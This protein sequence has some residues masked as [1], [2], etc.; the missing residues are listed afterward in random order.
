MIS[1]LSPWQTAFSPSVER[2]SGRSLGSEQRSDMQNGLSVDQQRQ[3]DALRAVDRKVRAH[4]L[5]HVAVG[6]GLVGAASFSYQVGPDKQRYA[7]AGEVSID[8]SE[9]RDAEETIARAE[10]IRAAAL[11]PADPSSQDRRVAALATRMETAARQKL[12]SEGSAVNATDR[13]PPV[14]S[15]LAAYQLPFQAPRTIGF[16]VF[17]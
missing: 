12:A 11:A 5:A 7:V 8:V 16:S 1:S 4:E 10:Q 14:S 17:A 13:G 3:V 2:G 6:G 15:A 9:G